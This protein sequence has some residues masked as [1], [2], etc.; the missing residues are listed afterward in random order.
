MTRSTLPSPRITRLAWGHMDVAGTGSGKDFKLW[1]GGAREWDWRE[2]GTHHDPGIQPADVEELLVH[3]SRTVVLSRGMLRMLRTCPDT[4]VLL[5]SR[6]I[7]VHVA[8]TK[9]A[10]RIY[11]DLAAQ[12]EAVG[13]LF[14]STC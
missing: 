5:E 10:A 3:G 13:G 1:P 14:H 9:K 11:N 7:A 4:L 12:G 2:T 6:G 8:E